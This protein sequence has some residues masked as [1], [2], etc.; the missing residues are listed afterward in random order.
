MAKPIATSKI[1]KIAGQFNKNVQL[2]KEK[3][4][5]EKEEKRK[6]IKT[7]ERKINGRIFNFVGIFKSKSEAELEAKKVNSFTSI[8]KTGK[9]WK[10]YRLFTI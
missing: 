9:G 1:R 2:L 6:S 3:E 7:G 4:K 5:R 10:L 8:E